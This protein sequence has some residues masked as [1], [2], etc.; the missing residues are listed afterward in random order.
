RRFSLLIG[1]AAFVFAVGP[2]GATT[3]A[4]PSCGGVLTASLHLTADLDCS[5]G[6]SDG[7]DIGADGI[8]VDLNGHTITGGGGADGYFG[9]NGAGHSNVTV[10]NGRIVNFKYDVYVGVA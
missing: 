1:I 4:L 10:K 2:A 9:V 5:A 7:L 3:K 8:V 6:G